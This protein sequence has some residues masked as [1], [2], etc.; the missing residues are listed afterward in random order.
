MTTRAD[1]LDKAKTIVTGQREQTYGG[2]E[3]SFQTIA[4]LWNAYLSRDSFIVQLTPADVA[5]MMV[6][7]KVARLSASPDHE[8]SWVDIA[9]YAACG[10]EIGTTGN[11][12][13]P[14][15]ERRAAEINDRLTGFREIEIARSSYKKTA[16]KE[17]NPEPVKNRELI[18]DQ[19][20]KNIEI[21]RS[22]AWVD[23]YDQGYRDG[24]SF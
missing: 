17:N 23:G 4:D 6:L 10:G 24:S 12:I 5:A 11:R 15:K 7:M 9:G 3:K 16:N 1:I 20:L 13:D 18:D 2:P 14:E 21:D 19:T 22:E 8:D